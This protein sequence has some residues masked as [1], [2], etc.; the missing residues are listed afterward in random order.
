MYY[1]L[2][3]F[4]DCYYMVDFRVALTSLGPGPNQNESENTRTM[5]NGLLVKPLSA[6]L[7]RTRVCQRT[8]G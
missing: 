4:I 5:H 6:K 8:G 3:S 7:S 2:S 1:F